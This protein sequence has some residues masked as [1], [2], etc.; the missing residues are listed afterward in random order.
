MSLFVFCN[1]LSHV[2]FLGDFNAH[3]QEWGF[4]RSRGEGVVLLTAALD[5]S[6]TCINDGSSTFLTR[7]NQTMSAIDL[8]FVSPPIIDLCEWSALEDTHLCDHYPLEIRFNHFLGKREFFSHRIRL[9][10]AGRRQFA[11]GLSVSMGVLRKSID[12][13]TLNAEDKYELFTCHLKKHLLQKLRLNSQEGSADLPG[14]HGGRSSLPAPWWNDACQ[15]AVDLRHRLLSTFKKSPSY[16]NYLAFK[17]QEAVSRRVLRAE[18]RKGWR[19]SPKSYYW[20][21]RDSHLED[22]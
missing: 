6:F 11:K 3:H 8:T 20:H 22:N 4:D 5:S 12:D 16:S 10:A 21:A 19:L 1:S 13:S 17:R 15:E 14:F 9:P 2:I 18:K 7:L